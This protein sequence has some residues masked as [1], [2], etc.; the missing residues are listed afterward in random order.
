MNLQTYYECVSVDVKPEKDI[1]D[2]RFSVNV[3]VIYIGRDRMQRQV[4][5]YYI[6]ED[7]CWADSFISDQIDNVIGW[8]RETTPGY[9]HTKEQL[10]ELITK[11]YNKGYA[12][13]ARN[14]I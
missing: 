2:P 9:F 13:G 10:E 1:N 3:I 7:D 5:G 4:K 8:L 12:E 14:N 11:G 6:F